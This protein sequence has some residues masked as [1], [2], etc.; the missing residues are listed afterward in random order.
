LKLPEAGVYGFSSG[1]IYA[2]G[3][4]SQPKEVAALVAEAAESDLLYST[5]MRNESHS[6]LAAVDEAIDAATAAGARL[7]ISH[8]KAMGPENYGLPGSRA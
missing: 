3:M 6:L 1:L 7:E 8:L 4:Y 5:H 2:P